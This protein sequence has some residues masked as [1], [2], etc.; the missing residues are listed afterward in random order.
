MLFMTFSTTIK[1]SGNVSDRANGVQSRL[2]YS[3]TY[4]L[5][6]RKHKSEEYE[7]GNDAVFCDTFF[8]IRDFNNMSS[9]F[10]WAI[11]TFTDHFINRLVTIEIKM[12]QLKLS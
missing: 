5:E 12:K 7:L 6:I 9:G 1:G 8:I 2:S 4:V 11:L 3:G 10:C